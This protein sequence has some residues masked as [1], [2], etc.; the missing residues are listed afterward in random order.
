MKNKQLILI[1]NLTYSISD[2]FLWNISN[3][4]VGYGDKIGL[5]GDNGSGKTTLLKI[6]NGEIE[7]DSGTCKVSGKVFVVPQKREVEGGFTISDLLSKYSIPKHIF[8]K[9]FLNSSKKLLPINTEM[10]KLSG[11]E[12]LKVHITLA[13]IIESDV[14]LLDE[15]TNHLDGIGINFLKDYLNNFKGAYI[16][17]SHD[18]G[19]L[20]SVVNKIW[21]IELNKVR[22]FSGNYSLYKETLENE[23]NSTLRQIEAKTKKL[24]KVKLAI[25]IEKERQQRSVS[26]GKKAKNDNSMSAYEKGYFKEHSEKQAG[27]KTN[28]LLSQKEEKEKE[29]QNFNIQ[30]RQKIRLDLGSKK[31]GKRLIVSVVDAQLILKNKILISNISFDLYTGDRIRINGDNGSGKTLLL[32]TLF[33]DDKTAKISG[34]ANKTKSLTIAYLDQHYDLVSRKNTVLENIK[35]ITQLND[36]TLLRSHLAGFMFQAE[37]MYKK[38]EFLSGG[39]LARLAIAMI[40]LSDFDCVVLDEPT[41]NLDISTLEIFTEALINFKGAII[42]VSHNEH[43]CKSIGVNKNFLISDGYFKK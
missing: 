13:K 12:F 20:N 19:F 9:E 17:V 8:E 18:I 27:K 37:D 15:P 4:M 43:F 30:K 29:L 11:G 1:E 24:K 38:A 3:L 22:T 16:C 34:I 42:V 26:V 35:N 36:E 23:Q 21:A 40:T 6:I 28:R 25:I 5:I 39:E 2:R 33:L 31:H 32:K 14:L 10:L 7:P 41:N